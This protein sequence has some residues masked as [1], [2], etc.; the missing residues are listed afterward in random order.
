M[1]FASVKYS[2]TEAKAHHGHST[3]RRNLLD[4]QV[5]SMAWSKLATDAS[6]DHRGVRQKT[7]AN[8]NQATFATGVARPDPYGFYGG[9]CPT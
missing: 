3:H 5:S 4:L 2:L 7:L 8:L 6:F 9:C 1:N